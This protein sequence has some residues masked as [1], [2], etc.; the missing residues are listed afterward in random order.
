M[1]EAKSSRMQQNERSMD[2]NYQ[3]QN[4]AAEASGRPGEVEC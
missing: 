1:L 2:A 4:E 3:Q